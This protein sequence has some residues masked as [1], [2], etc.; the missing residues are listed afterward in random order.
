MY[1][2]SPPSFLGYFSFFFSIPGKQSWRAVPGISSMHFEVCMEE[3]DCMEGILDLQCKGAA[4][5]IPSGQFNLSSFS[6]KPHLKGTQKCVFEND[7]PEWLF[8]KFSTKK[9]QT[10]GA[11]DNSAQTDSLYCL[12]LL[13]GFQAK[14]VRFILHTPTMPSL[15]LWAAA[16]PCWVLASFPLT[17]IPKSFSALK[18]PSPSLIQVQNFV[19]GLAEVCL[20]PLLFY[21]FIV[22]DNSWKS[23]LVFTAGGLVV[24]GSCLQ[25]Q[26][27]N[28]NDVF[29]GRFL[30]PSRAVKDSWWW[31]WE[32][33][34]V[35]ITGVY[36]QFW[37][38]EK[39]PWLQMFSECGGE[40]TPVPLLTSHLSCC[41]W[42]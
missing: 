37:S 29:T 34:G 28:A 41:R 1:V 39:L 17:S 42:C 25:E 40:K 32:Q 7:Q 22:W 13:I 35:Q 10:T 27:G 3:S 14:Q 38:K 11:S 16:S 5:H 12:Y 2:T 23:S 30:L 24:Q 21:L 8:S 26:M 15:T 20:G 33:S 19:C 4:N 18:P 31:C 9:N 36:S 6:V